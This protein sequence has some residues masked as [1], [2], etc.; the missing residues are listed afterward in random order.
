MTKKLIE[1]TCQLS[2][3]EFNPKN[4][5]VQVSSKYDNSVQNYC[6]E[7]AIESECRNMRENS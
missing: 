5:I 1:D 2:S 4:Y 3:F 6:A 7:I